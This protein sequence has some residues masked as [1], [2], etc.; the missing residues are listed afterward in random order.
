[1]KRAI[2]SGLILLFL[3]TLAVGCGNN[4]NSNNNSNDNNTQM[5]SDFYQSR[6]RSNSQVFDGASGE[7]KQPVNESDGAGNYTVPSGGGG[8]YSSSTRNRGDGY[9]D[10]ASFR[11]RQRS[12]AFFEGI[13]VNAAFGI[14]GSFR[15]SKNRYGYYELN[16]NV[17]ANSIGASSAGLVIFF[18]TVTVKIDGEEDFIQPLKRSSGVFISTIDYIGSAQVILPAPKPS[19]DLAVYL[20]VTY[21]VQT[22]LGAV[23]PLRVFNRRIPIFRVWE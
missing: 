19:L 16:I 7:W 8:A 9:I 22:P 15:I 18:G 10:G 1:M 20:T 13:G 4:N 12:Y 2:I 6:N 5:S 3:I 14:S 11:H 17:S 21:R 23:I